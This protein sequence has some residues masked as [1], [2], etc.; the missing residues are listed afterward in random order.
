MMPHYR[1]GNDVTRYCSE[2]TLIFF[3][4]GPTDRPTF[5]TRERE[6]GKESFYGDDLMYVCIL[7]RGRHLK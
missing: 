2:S 6:M 1:M 3:P 5:G 7:Q 4:F